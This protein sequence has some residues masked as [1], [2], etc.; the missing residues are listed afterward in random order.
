MVLALLVRERDEWTGVGGITQVP[1][2][3]Q[4]KALQSLGV[5]VFAPAGQGSESL[6]GADQRPAFSAAE[7]SPLHPEEKHPHFRARLGGRRAGRLEHAGERV[8][9]GDAGRWCPARWRSSRERAAD[10]R[11]PAV[12]A[13]VVAG[14]IV[15][16]DCGWHHWSRCPRAQA[17]DTQSQRVASRAEVTVNRLRFIRSPFFSPRTPRL[18]LSVH[19]PR[20]AGTPAGSIVSATWLSPS[21]VNL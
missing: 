5:V 20:Q 1:G 19:F 21:G 3:D 6:E 12:T 2:R 18:V 11:V 13:P 4:V 14:A 10:L 17:G 8:D 9:R 16:G 15:G 7:P